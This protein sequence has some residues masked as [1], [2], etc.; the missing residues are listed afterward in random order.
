LTEGSISATPAKS[1]FNEN[2]SFGA[3]G[4]DGPAEADFCAVACSVGC[5]G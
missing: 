2:F 3:A 1:K 4:C 5:V